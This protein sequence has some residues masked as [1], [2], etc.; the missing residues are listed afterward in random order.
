MTSF[1]RKTAAF[2]GGIIGCHDFKCIS[3]GEDVFESS[4][5]FCGTCEKTVKFNNGNTCIKCGKPSEKEVCE[6]CIKNSPQFDRAWSS[7]IYDGAVRDAMLAYKFGGY[8][9]I[10][11]HFAQLMAWRAKEMGVDFDIVTFVPLTKQDFSARGYNQTQLIAERL[12]DI[13]N[14]NPPVPLLEKVKQTEKQEKLGQKKRFLNIKDAFM[15]VP[16]QG[17]KVL[18]I[19]DVLTTGATCGECAKTLKKAGASAVYV[20][21][22]ATKV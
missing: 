1:F 17:Q 11:K 18:L 22:A 4:K 3:C 21:T 9:Y 5:H 12:C 14:L 16:L 10:A 6:E 15:S 19:D 7:L 2:I 8:R 13:L 20:L